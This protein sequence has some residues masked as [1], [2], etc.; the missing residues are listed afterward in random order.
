MNQP[1]AAA[2]RDAD[3]AIQPLSHQFEDLDQQN[4]AY[5][6][7]MWTFLVTEIMFFGALFLAYS[8]YRVLYTATYL[9]AHQFLS[10]PYGTLNTFVLLTSSL[11]MA[12]AVHAAQIGRRKSV[13]NWL[14]LTMILSFV[15][16]GVKAIEYKSK[17]DELLFPGPTFNFE[18]AKEE[19]AKHGGG[20]GGDH[21]GRTEPG[22]SA[23]GHGGAAA[24]G[25]S[26][27]MQTAPLQVRTGET[28]GEGERINPRT[29][30]IS[31]AQPETGFIGYPQAVT[32]ASGVALGTTTPEQA[33][34]N[35][36]SNRAQLFFSLYFAM[37]G[38][39]AV[40]IIIGILM[41]ATL[42]TLY[43]RRSPIVV[44][45]MPTEMI[46]LYWHFVDIV[47]IFL[48]PLMYLIS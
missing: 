36:E 21:G 3:G 46:G 43:H 41:M 15:F 42:W 30:G 34:K 8:V 25:A 10:I 23:G 35:I 38:L 27:M 11:A 16:L 40:H 2:H 13:M 48:F 1:R 7:G 12:L 24:R 33:T 14:A 20:H 6:V 37:T 19:N 28:G 32:S 45:Y 31:Y 44:D 5:V 22:Q 39:H 17:F 18:Y 4:E 9:D 29:V 26:S 47:W